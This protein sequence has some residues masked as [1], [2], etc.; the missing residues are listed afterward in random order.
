MCLRIAVT[1]IE[2]VAVNRGSIREY[3]ARQRERYKKAGNSEKGRILDEVVAVTNYHR[4]SAI[5]LLCDRKREYGGGRVGRPVVYGPKVAAAARTV[6]EA[7]G[8]IGAKRLHPFVGELATCLEVFGELEMDAETG[9][10]LRGASVATLERLLVCDQVAMRRKVRSLTKP[11]TLLR[12]RIAVRTFRDWDDARP[13]FIEVDTVAH[14]GD[15]MKGFRSRPYRK[16]DSAHVEQKNGA[17][18]RR[19]TGHSRYSS[20]AAFKQLQQVYSLA[21]LHV[22]F[23]QPVRRLS[24]KSREGARV[25]RYHDEGTTPYQ[26]MLQSG[27]LTGARETVMDKLYRSLNPLWLSRQIEVETEKLLRLAWRQGDSLSWSPTR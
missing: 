12:N 1:E 24:A 26:R 20:A 10:L 23:F 2:E 4:K 15:T 27:A 13:G 25:V 22:N 11:G 8:R 3:V 9:V 16:N 21:R 17:V 5:R 6:H 7:A 14:C 19:L 18:I